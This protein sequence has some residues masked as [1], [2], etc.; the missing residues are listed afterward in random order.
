MGKRTR[1]QRQRAHALPEPR[2][3]LEL[4]ARPDTERVPLGLI[5]RLTRQP[6]A[7]LRE[8]LPRAGVPVA[9]DSTVTVGDVRAAV[10]ARGEKQGAA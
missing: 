4:L 7:R 5:S 6:A 3:V 2:T 8:A 1:W 9:G 10:E